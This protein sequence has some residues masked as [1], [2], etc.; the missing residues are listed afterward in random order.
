[1]TSTL[2]ARAALSQELQLLLAD[3]WH[4]VDTNWGRTAGTYYT[5]DA[6]FVGEAATYSGR[7]KIE[8]FYAWRV[9]QGARLAV[10]A[11]NNFRVESMDETSARATWYLLLYAANGEPVLP[12]HPPITISLV[13]DDYVRADDGWLCQRRQ[14][15]TLFQGGA[16]AHNPKL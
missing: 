14:F 16:P 5:E 2:K 9:A 1:M 13:T 10:H 3:Y 8:Q 15:K 6:D 4:D 11:V 7:A 12:T